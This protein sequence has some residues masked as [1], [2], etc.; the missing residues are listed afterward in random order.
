MTG[1]IEPETDDSSIPWDSSTLYI[2]LASSLMGLMG[3]SLISPILPELRAV[4]G[5]SDA[6]I[7]LVITV[8]T[9]PGIFLTPFLGLIADRIGRRRVM[10]PLLVAFGGGG[11]GIAFASSFT[12]VLILRFV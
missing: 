3:V 10:I 4:F 1:E 12:E 5:V 2:I 9:L 6:Q 8:Y 11:A 7:G